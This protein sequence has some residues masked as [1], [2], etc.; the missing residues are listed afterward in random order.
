MANIRPCKIQDL[1][2]GNTNVTMEVWLPLQQAWFDAAIVT[3]EITLVGKSLDDNWES[4]LVI[5]Q[6]VADE[7]PGLRTAQDLKKPEYR[8]L[9][10]TPSSNGKA[11]LITCLQGWTCTD[12]NR[13][14]IAAY[15]LLDVVTLEVPGNYE[16]YMEEILGAF[17]REEPVLFYLWGPTLLSQELETQY[18]GF[19]LLEE[20][21]YTDACW[22]TDKACQ[23]PTSEI[24]IVVRSELLRSAP[25][26]IEFLKRWDF[27]ADNQL[28]VEGYLEETGASFPDVALWFLRNTREWQDWVTPEARAKVL[29]A[30]DG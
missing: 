5:P 25:D 3:G 20:P 12:V 4:A 7:Y 1:T 15:G 14:Q 9:F 2:Q 28:A 27:Q 10:V 30:L 11:R 17:E 6:W 21:E 29:A 24:F 8:E 16:D 23:Y 19:K 22:Q 26:A 18:G 13:M